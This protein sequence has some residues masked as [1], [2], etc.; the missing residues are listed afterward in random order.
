[1]GMY[2]ADHEMRKGHEDHKV[3]KNEHCEEG[4]TIDKLSKNYGEEDH[5]ESLQSS[6][7]LR[8]WGLL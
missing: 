6:G 4:V 7:T 3:H 5:F 8:S 1:M 2:N